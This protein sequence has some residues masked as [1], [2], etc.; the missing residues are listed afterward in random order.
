M[1]EFASRD[2]LDQIALPQHI[3]LIIHPGMTIVKAHFM[4]LIMLMLVQIHTLTHIIDPNLIPS[5]HMET[6]VNQ[7]T[8]TVNLIAAMANLIA[9]M[10]YL[11]T[12]TV[13]QETAI[14]AMTMVHYSA[15]TTIE[16]DITIVLRNAWEAAPGLLRKTVYRVFPT[17]DEM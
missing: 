16:I 5:H 10:V 4:S 14:I 7:I 13:N 12:A 3:D 15:V 9:T 8:T 6:M 1:N 17:V 2:M 11:T